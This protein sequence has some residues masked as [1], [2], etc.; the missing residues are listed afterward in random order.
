M[1]AAEGFSQPDSSAGSLVALRRFVTIVCALRDGKSSIFA[2]LHSS[3]PNRP[4]L[5]FIF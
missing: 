1:R 2:G 4:S 5:A 3:G